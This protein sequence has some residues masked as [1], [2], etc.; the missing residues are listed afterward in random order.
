MNSAGS[1][2]PRQAAAQ[3]QDR[4]A[5][6][7]YRPIHG[8]PRGQRSVEARRRRAALSGKSPC[9]ATTA[10]T[11]ARTNAPATDAA[12][13]PPWPARHALSTASRTPSPASSR[14]SG[15]ARR[16][17]RS[18]RVGED[19]A[20]LVAVPAEM[21][22]VYAAGSAASR[23]R[24]RA[25]R[26]R[27]VR[28]AAGLDRLRQRRAT[29]PPQLP[30]Q[31]AAGRGRRGGVEQAQGPALGPWPCGKRQPN[32]AHDRCARV[33]RQEAFR[34][35]I[36]KQLPRQRGQPRRFHRQPQAQAVPAAAPARLA[37]HSSATCPGERAPPQRPADRFEIGR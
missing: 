29:P 16:S 28:Q 23:P 15:P 36:A 17:R 10:G 37:R 33:Q 32:V 6:R 11:P 9:M 31:G 21:P 26:Q 22:D 18:L 34:S 25:A 24:G 12:C 4:F 2:Q 7:G 30:R 35:R 19:Q 8:L 20:L 27:L 1:H 3:R 13:P 5:A 14:P